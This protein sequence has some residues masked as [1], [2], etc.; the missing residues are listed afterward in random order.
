MLF[1]SFI[2]TVRE[3]KAKVVYKLKLK[4]KLM[5]DVHNIYRTWILRNE[6]YVPKEFLKYRI[7]C[8]VC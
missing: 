6:M 8:L 2:Y 1:E 4:M 5:Q 3:E 7:F